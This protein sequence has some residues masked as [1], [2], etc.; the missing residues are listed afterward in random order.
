[1]LLILEKAISKQACRQMGVG[2][3][4]ERSTK[5]RFKVV[6][7]AEGKGDPR[8]VSLRKAEQEARN[9]KLLRRGVQGAPGGSCSLGVFWF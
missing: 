7:L 3:L 2:R 9:N 4:R 6:P 5:R 1:M 8:R